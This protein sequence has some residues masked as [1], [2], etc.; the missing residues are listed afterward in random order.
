[1]QLPNIVHLNEDGWKAGIQLRTMFAMLSQEN[2]NQEKIMD[3]LY[4]LSASIYS[5]QKKSF[6]EYQSIDEVI[7]TYTE[8]ISP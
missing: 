6:K 7:R 4:K 8:P 3:E 2:T 1:M 5:T